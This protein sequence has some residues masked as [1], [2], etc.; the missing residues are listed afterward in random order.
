MK[1][2]IESDLFYVIYEGRVWYALAMICRRWALK[3]AQEMVRGV[4]AAEAAG[5]TNERCNQTRQTLLAMTSDDRHLSYE[6]T[7]SFM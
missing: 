3:P 4:R 6:H 1:R 5:W 2:H 7:K